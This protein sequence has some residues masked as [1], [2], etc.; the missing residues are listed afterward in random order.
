MYETAQTPC[1]PQRLRALEQ[2]NAIRLARAELKRR[3]AEGDTSVADVI[4]NCP[5][6]ARKWTISELLMAQRRWGI[7]RC[8][9]FL[10]RNG[11]SEIKPIG[12]LTER[13]RRMLVD[14]LEELVAHPVHTEDKSSADRTSESR[15]QLAYV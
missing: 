5:D 11:I 9:K 3:I 8:R 14:Q 12:A 7:T 13:Q 10:E 2:A 6:S 1:E 4:L 15:R